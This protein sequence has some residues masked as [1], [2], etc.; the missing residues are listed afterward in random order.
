M[1]Q[2]QLI[3]G[4]AETLLLIV[5]AQNEDKSM[6]N[7]Q[8]ETALETAHVRNGVPLFPTNPMREPVTMEL[9]KQLMD[10]EV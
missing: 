6:F 2:A 5:P 10:E 9:V 7:A 3:Q 1:A 4:N 8:P